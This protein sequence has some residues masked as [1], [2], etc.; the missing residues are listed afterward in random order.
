MIQA[1]TNPYYMISSF[2]LSLF[3]MAI[4]MWGKNLKN[5]AIKYLG[6]LLMV[7]PAV[8]VS[9]TIHIILFFLILYACIKL[10]N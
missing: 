8:S 3:G 6:V 7:I 4:F 9:I 1:F 2:V 10:N 5:M